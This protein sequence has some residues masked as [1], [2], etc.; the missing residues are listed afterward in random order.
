MDPSEQVNLP[1]QIEVLT[2]PYVGSKGMLD[3]GMEK[4][5]ASTAQNHFG[6]E[7]EIRFKR[8]GSSFSTSSSSNEI[9]RGRF[10]YMRHTP[11]FADIVAEDSKKKKIATFI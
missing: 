11:P 7:G 6:P 9:M 8:E 10:D 4:E 3:L 5:G 1:P 2:Q